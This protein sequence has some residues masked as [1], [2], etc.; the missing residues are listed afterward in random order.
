MRFFIVGAIAA[1]AAVVVSVAAPAPE[2][3]EARALTGLPAYTAGF[4]SWLRL[5]RRPIPPRAS[6]PHFGSKNVY[7]SLSRRQ[8]TRG[9]RQRYPYP[10]GSIVVKS[11][12]RPGQSFVSLVA[13]MRKIRGTNRAHNDWA[14][15]EY[16]RGSARGRFERIASGATCTSCH[17][18]ARRRDYVFTPLSQP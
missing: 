11:A 15:I 8:L 6:D 13:V 7:V 9:G 1:A 16:T 14:M 10:Y 2:R 4:E 17:V 18:Q 3:V 12:K 5:N